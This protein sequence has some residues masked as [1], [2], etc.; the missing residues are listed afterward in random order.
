MAKFYRVY[1][2]SFNGHV[3]TETAYNIVKTQIGN[4]DPRFHEVKEISSVEIEA[5]ERIYDV[6]DLPDLGYMTTEADE[7]DTT[8]TEQSDDGLFDDDSDLFS[9]FNENDEETS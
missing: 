3:F 7:T 8:L 6:D 4:G 5:N 9:G 1:S 2:D